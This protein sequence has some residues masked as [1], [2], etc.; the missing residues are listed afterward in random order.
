MDAACVHQSEPE[1]LPTDAGAYILL[2]RLD[3][4]QD[5][6]HGKAQSSLAPGWLAYCGSAK[7][8]GGLRARLK[9]HF[10]R[11]KRLHWHVDRLTLG[12][13]I[14]AALPLPAAKECH[15][16]NCLLTSPA[17]VV[18]AKGF[19]NSDCTRCPSHLLR[20]RE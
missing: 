4:P 9:R 16:M 11:E 8:P 14:L 3:D 10:R 13:S 1:G 19:G 6:R 18:A 12:A 5:I 15:L 17:F 2:L 7:G 20:F